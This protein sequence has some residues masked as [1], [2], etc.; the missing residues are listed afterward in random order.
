[1]PIT[2]FGLISKPIEDILKIDQIPVET[3]DGSIVDFTLPNGDA[4]ISGTLT[5]H[6]DGMKF[7]KANITE[8]SDTTFRTSIA[9]DADETL[10]IT[11]IKK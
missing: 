8:T 10:E 7:L 5:A 6:I 9:P 2:E 3:P 1:M 11:Y 4:Y